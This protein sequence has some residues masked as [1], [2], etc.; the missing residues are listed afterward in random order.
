[1]AGLGI[2][3]VFNGEECLGCEQCVDVCPTSAIRSIGWSGM[4]IMNIE[5]DGCI[6]CM[7]CCDMCPVGCISMYYL[8]NGRNSCTGIG[9]NEV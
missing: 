6:G 7:Q 3:M 9:C 4:N 2:I 1:M 8:G 5:I